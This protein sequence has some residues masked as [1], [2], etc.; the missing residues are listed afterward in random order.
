MDRARWKNHP[1]V[2]VGVDKFLC[3]RCDGV[4]SLDCLAK[5]RGVPLSFCS[6]CRYKGKTK[7][8][9]RDIESYLKLRM[10]TV[11]A[12][13]KECLCPCTIT[14][15]DLLTQLKKQRGKCFYTDITLEPV[16]GRGKHPHGLSVDRLDCSKGYVLGNVVLCSNRANTIKS[17]QTLSE[18]EQWMPTWYQKIMENRNDNDLPQVGESVGQIAA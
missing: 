16:M 18:L 3:S 9:N 17:D 5:V 2:L 13:A 15:Q 11:K 4:K 12:R 10:Q 14:F 8:A 7:R 1:L 6:T